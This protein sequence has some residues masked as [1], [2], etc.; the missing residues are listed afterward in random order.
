MIIAIA[1]ITIAIITIAIISTI[2]SIFCGHPSRPTN[3]HPPNRCGYKLPFG[4]RVRL[5]ELLLST[6]FDS[7]A[8]APSPMQTARSVSSVGGEVG[9]EVFVDEKDEVLESLQRL[10]WPVLGI[11]CEH[12]CKEISIL[13]GWMGPIDVWAMGAVRFHVCGCLRTCCCCCLYDSAC[14]ACKQM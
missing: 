13:A 1:I 14:V 6:V 7:S 8:P 12:A 10:V 4:L 11:R 3:A 5:C 2:T 9:G